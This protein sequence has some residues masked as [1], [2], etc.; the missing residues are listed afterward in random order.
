MSDINRRLDSISRPS[1]S[2][3]K[4]K[5][6]PKVV[7]RK[8]KS[9]RDSHIT[10]PGINRKAL[11]AHQQKRRFM[12]N[13]GRSNK[14]YRDTTIVSAGPL[15]A[16]AVSMGSVGSSSMRSKSISPVS[17][18]VAKLRQRDDKSKLK[19]EMKS[20]SVALGGAGMP[21]GDEDEEDDNSAQ[22]KDGDLKINMGE[23]LKFSP[24]DLKYFPVRAKRVQHREP[25]EEDE[26]DKT[27]KTEFRRETSVI[28]SKENS[29]T[30]A[31]V[32]DRNTPELTADGEES[33][34]QQAESIDAISEAQK[35]YE[36]ESLM[37]DY[38]SIV[39]FMKKV[40]IDDGEKKEE[41]HLLDT[42]NAEKEDGGVKVK[43][44]HDGGDLEAKAD[45]KTIKE[46]KQEQKPLPGCMFV[47]FPA[48]LPEF[49][50]AGADSG[51]PKV[52]VKI[53]DGEKSSKQEAAS[54]ILRERGAEKTEKQKKLPRGIIGKL[55]YH[56]SGKVS[57]KIGNVIFDVMRGAPGN[58]RQDIVGID[59][60]NTKCYD[61]GSVDEVV[62]AA[63]KL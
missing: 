57:M 55:R 39:K 54:R 13:K 12:P 34:K 6:R 35:R 15:S 38:S 60:N 50:D 31:P 45:D 9:E 47:Q 36:R 8:P 4:L 16:G 63:P 40:E 27:V 44:E 22:A 33:A 48:L 5:F 11:R 58:F 3:H 2:S 1:K 37:E 59:K 30:P 20:D 17:D 53:E 28:S 21:Y 23:E 7:A 46:V 56:K 26:P 24:E 18:L 49:E 62:I 43:T 25:G 52:A 61:L 42:E 10:T 51:K 32:S 19:M 41:S 14:K 29:T